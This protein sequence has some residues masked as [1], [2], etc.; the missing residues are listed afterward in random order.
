MDAFG[1]FPNAESTMKSLKVTRTFII[2]VIK[3]IGY[4][5]AV[6]CFSVANML[7]LPGGVHFVCLKGQV[8]QLLSN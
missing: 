1:T 3:L 4:V 8:T 2:S 6:F 5:G 7:M